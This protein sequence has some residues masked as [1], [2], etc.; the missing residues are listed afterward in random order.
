MQKYLRTPSP[1]KFDTMLTL[2]SR[3]GADFDSVQVDLYEVP[4][5][6][7]FGD[8]IHSA[9]R[10]WERFSDSSY[11]DWLGQLMKLLFDNPGGREFDSPSR[12]ATRVR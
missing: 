7:V 9:W 10:G 12:G 11:T 8:L 3:L 1:T 5:R 4:V 2:S 6:I